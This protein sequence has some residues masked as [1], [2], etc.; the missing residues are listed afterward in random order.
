MLPSPCFLTWVHTHTQLSLPL[1]QHLLRINFKLWV[2]VQGFHALP[3]SEAWAGPFICNV[4]TSPPP[5]TP[6]KFLVLEGLT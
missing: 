2:S 6:I 3:Y 1:P 4:A 5:D